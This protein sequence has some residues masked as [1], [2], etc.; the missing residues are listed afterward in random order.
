MNLPVP[1]SVG[2]PQAASLCPAPNPMLQSTPTLILRNL[3][4]VLLALLS[5]VSPALAQDTPE[6]L[7]LQRIRDEAH[8][9]AIQYRRGLRRKDAMK[10]GLEGV[11]GIGQKR[12]Q[13]VLDR[14]RTLAKIREAS[15]EELSEVIGKKLA[16]ALQD[17][18]RKNPAVKN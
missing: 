15:T 1:P 17:A 10:T 2:P 4:L 12:Q 7:Y 3:P 16:L 11:P 8:R 5:T 6:S 9:F 14:F 13:A 18:L